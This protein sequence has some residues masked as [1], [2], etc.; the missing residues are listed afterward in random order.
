MACPG[1]G[2]HGM[3]WCVPWHAKTSRHHTNF[4]F[5]RAICQKCAS[6]FS[7]RHLEGVPSFKS[8]V[9]SGALV[10]AMACQNKSKPHKFFFFACA[11]CLKCVYKF[12]IRYLEG[13]PCFKSKFCSGALVGA[14]ACLGVCHGMPKRVDAAQIF[15]FARAICPKCVS[16]F[17]IRHLKGVPSFKSKVCSGALVGAKACLGVCHGMP[18][19]VDTAQI[20]VLPVPFAQIVFLSPL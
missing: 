5:A 9:H 16:K 17:I 4:C 3:P 1:G 8:K 12:I 14:M 13:V 19:R 7:I 11:I 6:K 15:C 10:G 18:K 20:F 2:C